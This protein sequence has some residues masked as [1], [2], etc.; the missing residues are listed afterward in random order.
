MH[1]RR[2][3]SVWPCGWRTRCATAAAQ[4]TSGGRNNLVALLLVLAEHE[5]AQPHFALTSVLRTAIVHSTQTERKQHH[6]RP[7]ARSY[8]SHQHE[9]D[10]VTE[11]QLDETAEEEEQGQGGAEEESKELLRSSEGEE[12][13][14]EDD[15]CRWTQ[16]SDACDLEL[17]CLLWT[18]LAR[19]SSHWLCAAHIHHGQL[20]PA[21][22]HYVDV[23]PGLD[24]AERPP[25]QHWLLRRWSDSQLLVLQQHA[26]LA[27][28]V[29]GPSLVQQFQQCAGVERLVAYVQRTQAVLAAHARPRLPA[30]DSR[31]PGRRRQV[32]GAGSSCHVCKAAPSGAGRRHR[33]QH[34]VLRLPAAVE[35]VVLAVV[36]RSL[37][38]SVAVVHSAVS[39]RGADPVHARAS[40]AAADAARSV[41]RAGRPVRA[42]AVSR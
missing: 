41:V 38:C 2:P 11:Q 22:L 36:G 42:A 35:A 21:L 17:R 32:P 19:L 26:L 20:L 31:S 5:A 23:T 27:L 15:E 4:R 25:P 3:R 37:C 18:L 24:V 6:S 10:D 14:E 29:L 16:S 12:G 30:P 34:Q 9:A 8:R 28:T 33:G 7:S 39:V 13:E 40:V 1:R